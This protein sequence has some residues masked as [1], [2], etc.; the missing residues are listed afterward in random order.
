MNPSIWSTLV[1]MQRVARPVCSQAAKKEHA[2]NVAHAFVVASAMLMF[3]AVSFAVPAHSHTTQSVTW[4][5][6]GTIADC[7]ADPTQP[8]QHYNAQP[9]WDAGMDNGQWD[10]FADWDNETYTPDDDQEADFNHGFIEESVFPAPD[11]WFNDTGNTNVWTTDAE[12]ILAK[13]RII[14][15]FST[16]SALE[17]VTSPVSGLPLETGILFL[18]AGNQPAA[19]INIYWGTSTQYPDVDGADALFC[20]TS[21]ACDDLPTYSLVFDESTD[22]FFGADKNDMQSGQVDLSTVALHEIGHVVGLDHQDDTDDI[23]HTY[24][25]DEDVIAGGGAFRALSDDD[26]IGAYSLY[27]IPLGKDF[28]DAPDSYQT[29]LGSNGP[30]YDEGELQRL[31]DRWDAEADGQPTPGADGDDFNLL[32]VGGPDDEDG[33]LISGDDVWIDLTILRPEENAYGLRGWLDQGDDGVFD[34]M[35]DMIIDDLLFLEPGVHSFHYVVPGADEH[36]S[37]FR[38]TWI[39]DPTGTFG[40]VSFATDVTPFG[41]FLGVDELSHGE[42][43]DYPPIPEPVTLSLLAIGGLMLARRRRQTR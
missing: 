34:H 27:S 23:M 36:Y 29:L 31:G 37:R 25:G 5:T 4:C 9:L 10:G 20:Q 38:L 7:V 22:W 28:G 14:E 26:K 15:A 30:R 13:P 41:E 18:E 11:F 19:E 43:E 6:T 1:V 33:V 42:V 3:P 17:A 24:S 21:S 35:G 40:G 12:A 8:H 32:G 16:W 39:D 2:L